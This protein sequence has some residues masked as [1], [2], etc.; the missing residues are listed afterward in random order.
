VLYVY[1]II[2]G[3]EPER[4]A[5]KPGKSMMLLKLYFSSRLLWNVEKAREQQTKD[6]K[7]R[8]NCLDLN[9]F[10][11]TF[12]CSGDISS[13]HTKVDQLTLSFAWF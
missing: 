1:N 3:N 10:T 11:Q 8:K 13:I 2:E 9:N 4:S 5:L 12:Q 7:Q 6:E